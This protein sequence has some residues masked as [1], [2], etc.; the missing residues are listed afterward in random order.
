M[1]KNIKAIIFDADD[2]LINH[3]ECEKQA[4]QYLFNKIGKKYKNQY[5]NI[6]R[7]LDWKL[8]D[9]VANKK[10][11]IPVE[12][13]P[14]YRFEIFF[15]Q[16]NLEYNNYEKANELFK[17][18]FAKTSALTQNAYE[19]V[20]Y[21]YYKGYKI[22]II[23][24]G[25]VELQKPRI[26][27]SAIVSYISDIIIS[28]QVGVAKPNCKIF[29]ILLEKENLTSDEVIMIGDSLEK[30]IK[31]AKNANIKSVWY[32]PYNNDNNYDVVPDYQIKDL[33]DIKKLL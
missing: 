1:L 6:F 31:G 2:T 9:D 3:K 18:G 22:Y 8:W 23:T 33:L 25:I 13:I 20:K 19:I 7:P 28:E 5:Q 4:L 29:N 26:M 15:Q 30:D 11:I 21:L 32:N 27:N 10:S 24:N 17:E 16:I 12:K 14:E